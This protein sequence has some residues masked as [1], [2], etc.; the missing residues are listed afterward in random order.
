MNAPRANHKYSRSNFLTGVTINKSDCRLTT[1]QLSKPCSFWSELLSFVMLKSNP[2]SSYL[3]RKYKNLT[4]KIQRYRNKKIYNMKCNVFFIILSSFV[5]PWFY[6]LLMQPTTSEV[7]QRRQV[8][9]RKPRPIQANG[10]KWTGFGNTWWKQSDSWT[11]EES[12]PR[13]WPVLRVPMLV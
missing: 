13:W 10:R 2:Q 8:F 5:R 7:P 3:S 12:K 6:F 1:Y 9:R 11:C 4:W